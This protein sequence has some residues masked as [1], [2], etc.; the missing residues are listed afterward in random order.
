MSE[1]PNWDRIVIIAE[2]NYKKRLWEEVGRLSAESDDS[3]ITE[4]GIDERIDE[5]LDLIAIEN[6][7]LNPD[8]SQSFDHEEIWRTTGKYYVNKND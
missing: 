3:I 1:R 2:D 7:R 6:E 5:I 4:S 8:S